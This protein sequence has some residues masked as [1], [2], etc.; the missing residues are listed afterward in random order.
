MD[1]RDLIQKLD[2]I[3]SEAKDKDPVRLTIQ[4]VMPQ[5]EKI[6][7]SPPSSTMIKY[8]SAN[9]PAFADK[10]INDPKIKAELFNA[11]IKQSP[12]RLMGDIAARIKPTD[13]VQIEI[14]NLMNNISDKI[15]EKKPI[16]KDES[17]FVM[18][19]M[20]K[21]L[22]DMPLE[23]DPDNSKYDDNEGEDEFED[24]QTEAGKLKSGKKDP[25]WSGYEMVGMKKKGGKEVPNCVPKEDNVNDDEQLDEIP[26][27]AVAS[28]IGRGVA[29]GA[30]AV[31]GAAV[32]GAQAVGKGAAAG[33]KAVG[34][35]TQKGVQG[36]RRVAGQ[37]KMGNQTSR[38]ITGLNALMTKGTAQGMGAQ[39]LQQILGPIQKILND[40]QLS[41]EFIRLL[42]KAEA[43]AGQQ[44]MQT[45]DIH[46]ES[47]QFDE[48]VDYDLIEN[49]FKEYH[50][51]NEEVVSEKH[52]QDY[53]KRILAVNKDVELSG[54]SIWDKEGTNPKSVHVKEIKVIYEVDTESDNPADRDETSV[55]VYVEHDGPWTIYTDSGFENE[56]SQ[57]IGIDVEFTEQ[58]MQDDGEASLEGSVA[59]KDIPA[60]AK[61][62][63]SIKQEDDMSTGTV[64]VG[65]KGKTRRATG[66]NDNPYDHNEG[67]DETALANAALWNMKD[68]YQT[69]MA[70]EEVSEDDMFSYG[71]LVQ[72]LEQADMPDHYSKFWDLVTDAINKAGGFAGQGSSLEVD[73]NIAPK[74]KTLYQ[75]FKA[76]TAEVKGVKEGDPK[77][78]E[79]WFQGL[80]DVILNG[81][82]FYE[83][84]GWVGYDDESIE[85]A[86]YQGRSV[87]LNKP[88]RGDVKK[89][90]VYVKNPKGNVVKVNFGDPDMKIKRSI[91]ARRKSFR[92][93][94]NCDSPGPKTKAR[95]W[96]CKKW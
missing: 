55:S 61:S 51:V 17:A 12:G 50:A 69:I 15:A 72:Y 93:R 14:S 36:L 8:S 11:E 28:G 25:C 10:D 87:K 66:I 88:M 44:Q 90:K 54:D 59:T 2:A 56:I 13:D 46:N 94:H 58:G 7:F 35:M 85:E 82:E 24:V 33:A 76:A 23:K 31:G 26:I 27:G 34:K 29:A 53:K 73:K 42:K 48:V 84:F 41:T 39:G 78:D 68:V 91:P 5:V 37:M 70:G 30:K 3:A 77:Y 9:N 96:S 95:Y 32:K 86:E 40:P 65:K 64:A 79:N 63:E 22:K 43:K 83:T 80:N 57:M 52:Y 16:S 49:I 92:A 60:D 38:M 18:A 74:I 89:F 62:E 20:K 6:I 19:V 4:D 81:D 67:E 75:Q 71:D 21:A 45:N 1:I 47:V